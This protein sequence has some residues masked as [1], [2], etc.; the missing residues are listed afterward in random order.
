MKIHR[1]YRITIP[2][3]KRDGKM[4][5]VRNVLDRMF[6]CDFWQEITADQTDPRIDDP[7]QDGQQ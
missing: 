3:E 5:P 6:F 2:Q 1:S 7:L 4:E